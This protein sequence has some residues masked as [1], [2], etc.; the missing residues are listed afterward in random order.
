MAR[1]NEIK[2]LKGIQNLKPLGR[3]QEAID[4]LF[5]EIEDDELKEDA[6]DLAAGLFESPTGRVYALL[7]FNAEFNFNDPDQIVYFAEVK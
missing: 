7:T 4:I 3:S 2:N 5:N 6:N 1:S